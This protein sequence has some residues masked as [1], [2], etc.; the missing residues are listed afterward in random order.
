[1]KKKLLS[2]LSLLSVTFVASA[3]NPLVPIVTS[4]DD[5]SSDALSDDNHFKVDRNTMEEYNTRYDIMKKGEN[6]GGICPSLGDV[7]IL[8]VPVEFSDFPADEIGK[9]YNGERTSNYPSVA[10]RANE[11]DWGT[12]RGREN[13]KEDIRK[14]FF[15]NSEETSWHSVR[16]YYEESSY[17]R[18]H[19]SGFVADWFKVYLDESTMEWVSAYDWANGGSAAILARTIRSYYTDET[20]RRYREFKDEYGNVMFNSGSE[21]LKYFDSNSDGYFDYIQLV[22]S[23]PFYAP[24]YDSKT[25]KYIPINN[26]IFWT[27]CGRLA[28]NVEGDINNSIINTYGFTSYYNFMVGGHYVND[29]WKAWTPTEISDG[30]ALVD[31]HTINRELGTAMGLNVLYD[32]DYRYCGSG[33]ID[34]M[35]N[36]IGD[37]NSCHKAA[38]GWVEPTFVTGPTEVKI[39]PFEDTGDCIFVPYRG[40][41]K[42]KDKN[43][44]T[45]HMEYLAIELYTPEGLNF[46]DSERQFQGIYP[47]APTQIGIKVYHVDARLGL[48]N[49]NA[50][51]GWEFSQ[52]VDD[53]NYEH[54]PIMSQVRIASTN[55]ASNRVGDAW[56]ISYLKRDPSSNEYLKPTEIRN[57]SLWQAGDTINWN[58]PFEPEFLMNEKGKNGYVIPFGYKMKIES[59]ERNYAKI[60]FY[61]L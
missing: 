34:M 31:T 5:S 52:F 15:G 40:Y 49:F 16:S 33:Q 3:C 38:L 1:M 8:V 55:T 14:A 6:I 30:I 28:Q 12:G 20:I 21:F 60:A 9:Y 39:R 56:E 37:H 54:D 42:D 13:A 25:D 26:D 23:A 43:R 57:S 44:F 61:A 2:L 10:K 11:E 41:F 46:T 36:A 59:I 32:L 4:S 27:Y 58:V 19:F 45:I 48:W 24:Y 18:L 17:S 50:N 35:D 51:K 29:K 7:N 22:Y 47:L 53:V